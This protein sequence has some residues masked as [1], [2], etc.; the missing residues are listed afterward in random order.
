MLDKIIGGLMGA[1]SG[2]FDFFVKMPL[3]LITGLIDWIAGIMGFDGVREKLESMAQGFINMFQNIGIPSFTI[4]M[5]DIFGGDRTFPGFFPFKPDPE[6][7]SG[8]EGGEPESPVVKVS[9]MDEAPVNIGELKEIKLPGIGSALVGE[10]EDG[11]FTFTNTDGQTGYVAPGSDLHA[12]MKESLAGEA[13]MIDTSASDGGGVEGATTDA[14]A[15]TEEA[16]VGPP[17]GGDNIIIGGSSAS[18]S[19]SSTYNTYGTKGTHSLETR[20]KQGYK[21]IC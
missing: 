21:T 3:D 6:P 7:E 19:S 17:A 13:S 11:G 12:V 4:P 8:G 10:T 9:E 15:A 2:L 5:P 18:S 1:V 20:Q 14:L 16:S